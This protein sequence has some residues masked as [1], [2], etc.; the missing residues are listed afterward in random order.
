MKSIPYNEFKFILQKL[1]SYEDMI[2]QKNFGHLTQV[3]LNDK[4]EIDDEIYDSIISIEKRLNE[5]S[6]YLK[7]EKVLVRD[8]YK[9]ILK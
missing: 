7:T 1:L 6:I 8:E 3:N 2:F 4:V 9:T 5:I